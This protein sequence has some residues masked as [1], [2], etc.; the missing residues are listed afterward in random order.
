LALLT[1]RRILISVN[2]TLVFRF[3][4]QKKHEIYGGCCDKTPKKNEANTCL[5][6]SST[7]NYT[8]LY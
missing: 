6:T 5:C 1:A 8:E 3:F 7:L 4:P 2:I